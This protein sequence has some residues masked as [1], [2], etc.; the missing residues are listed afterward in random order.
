MS[1]TLTA[2]LECNDYYWEQ[3]YN[4]KAQKE[5]IP[6]GNYMGGMLAYYNMD[7]TPCINAYNTEEHTYFG[8]TGTK[9]TLVSDYD[10]FGKVV[11]LSFGA[12]K[13]NSFVRMPNPLLNHSDIDGFTVSM[14]V[15]RTDNNMWDAIWGFFNSTSASAAGPR[16]FLTG[17]N[18]LGYNDN[19]GTY[20][21]INHPDNGTYTD[22][23]VGEWALV[24][25]TFGPEN[26]VRTYINGSTKA[27]HKVTCSTGTTKTKELPYTEVIEKVTA[28][29]Y[30]YLGLG[31]F[32]GSVD[33]YIDDLMIYN[34]EL[35][36]TDVRALNTMANRVTDFTKGEGGT[37]I[38]EIKDGEVG[39]KNYVF[40]LQGR[41][42]MKPTRG[43]YIVN[44]KKILIQ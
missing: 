7:E 23:P 38:S 24:T 13:N 12:Q 39:M 9:P 20:F 1:V 3:A 19:A 18:Y 5:V 4:V 27:A 14:W 36:S 25:I 28:M 37:G 42:I 29:K 43:L 30:F 10:R 21:D 15:K 34:R 41:R 31:S 44:G 22:I 33:C 6:T 11:H 2:R 35:T 32:W 16:L 8:T 40:D 26:G 17:N